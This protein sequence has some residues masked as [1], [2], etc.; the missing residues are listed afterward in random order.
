MSSIKPKHWSSI[1]GSAAAPSRCGLFCHCAH[2]SHRLLS[3]ST[4]TALSLIIK[5]TLR[6]RAVADYISD[7]TTARG[8]ESS[9]IQTREPGCLLQLC[10]ATA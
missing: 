2:A 9:S 8:T 7:G 1:Y 5:L 3:G 4:R 6:A 10:R